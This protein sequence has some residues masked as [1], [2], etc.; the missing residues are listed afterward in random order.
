MLCDILP[1][2]LNAHAGWGELRMRRV[3]SSHV[4]ERR[5]VVEVRGLEKGSDRILTNSGEETLLKTS[6]HIHRETQARLGP[7]GA[8]RPDR[9]LSLKHCPRSITALTGGICFCGAKG[10]RQ[11]GRVVR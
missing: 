1:A 4:F 11:V 7:T 9:I 3:G 6:L 5:A 2:R 8:G 10:N